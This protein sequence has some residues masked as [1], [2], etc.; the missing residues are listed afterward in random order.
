MT[1]EPFSAVDAAWLHM[2]KPTNM[3]LIVG[4][5]MFDT[6]IDF[7]RFKA[8]VEE[9]LLI[10]DRFR[11][12]V[13]EPRL[14]IG[15]PWWEFDPEF[16]LDYHVQRLKLPRPGDEVML[17]KLAGVLM[18]IPLDPRR[19]L[20]QFH[21]VDGYGKGCAIIPRLHH[22]IGDGLALVQVLLSMTDTAPDAE[23]H[24]P[25]AP[26]LV[27]DL[28]P[29]GN[30]LQPVTGVVSRT[31][32]AAESLAHEG[33]VT[34][35]HPTRLV[36]AA[37][38]GVLGVLAASKLLLL[39]EDRQ[40]VFRGQCGIEKRAM[41]STPMSLDDVMLVARAMDATVNDVL[42]AAVTGALRR[43]LEARGQSVS[44]LNIRTMVPVSIRAADDFDKLGN[45]FGL[46]ILSLPIGVRDPIRRIVILKQR[47]DD[48]KGTPEAFVA[49]GILGTMGLTPVQIEDI[50]VKIFGAKV[51]AVMTN[52]PGPREPI[53]LAG[54]QLKRIMF[55][56]PQLANLSLGVSILSY[57]GEVM[58]GVATD[59]GLVPDPEH[60]ITAFDDE[61]ASMQDW[62]K[63][64]RSKLRT[65][66]RLKPAPIAAEKDRCHATTK[67][68]QLC[69][70]RALPGSTVCKVHQLVIK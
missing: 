35:A 3:A 47:M 34:I 50:I 58:V 28:Q 64:H 27:N 21:F 26:S 54:Q 19:P 57:A 10:H 61:F 51:S 59:A 37:K 66:K 60:I 36:D 23:R 22:C 30:I 8:I 39:G 45:Q 12:R 49:F 56:V 44:G 33:L 18:S 6:P 65:A 48:I 68:G 15:L 2:D 20:W 32:G 41:W 11:Q 70:N 42:L 16:D 1:T 67:S 14:H 7:K 17:Q 5:M 9:R 69:R 13:K 31:V 53:Y 55:W 63:V 40:T 4:V 52:V 46:V 62:V 24:A 29:W 25:R 43:Y 38:I